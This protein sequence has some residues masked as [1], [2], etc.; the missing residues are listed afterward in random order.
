MAVAMASGMI[1]P[2]SAPEFLAS[3]GWEGAEN[4]T[5][6]GT[7]S[8]LDARGGEEIGGN[9]GAPAAAARPT[10]FQEQTARPL[11]RMLIGGA[12]L[13]AAAGIALVAFARRER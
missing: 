12:L 6:T 9:G 1:P 2:A 11:N 5:S 4:E 8:R 3:C 10:P 7:R 13:G